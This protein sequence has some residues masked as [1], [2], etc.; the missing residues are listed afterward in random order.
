[1]NIKA[2]TAGWLVDGL[3]FEIVSEQANNDVKGIVHAGYTAVDM[4][5]KN[6]EL[7]WSVPNDDRTSGKIGVSAYDFDGDGVDEVIVQDQ[8]RVRI[9]DGQTGNERAIIANSSATLWEYPI[10]VDL[11]GDNNAELIVVAND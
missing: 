9:L 5:N 7:I 4:Y 1:R 3:Q 8:M 11:A 6:G 2:W 10:V